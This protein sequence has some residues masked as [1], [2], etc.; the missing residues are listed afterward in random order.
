MRHECITFR[1]R[2]TGALYAWELERR[3][4]TWRVPVR[5]GVVTD[6]NA[7]KVSLAEQLPEPRASVGTAASLRR[8]DEAALRR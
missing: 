6:D 5:G 4:R 2:T 1:S 7:L 8:G 3:K